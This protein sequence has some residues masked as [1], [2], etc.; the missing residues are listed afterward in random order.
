MVWP[1]HH[2]APR[3]G[4]KIICRN[5]PKVLVWPCKPPGPSSSVATF[6][7]GNAGVTPPA[8]KAAPE[9]NALDRTG[10][11]KGDKIYLSGKIGR[12]NF[13][14]ALYLYQ[15]HTVLGPLTRGLDNR[16]PY[17][18][19]EAQLIGHYASGCIDTSDGTFSALNTLS[20]LNGLGYRLQ[21]LP[22][23]SLPKTLAHLFRRPPELLVLRGG[24]GVRAPLRHPAGYRSRLPPKRQGRRAQILSPGGVCPRTGGERTSPSRDGQG[25]DTFLPRSPELRRQPRILGSL[26]GNLVEHGIPRQQ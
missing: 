21:K 11:Q 17:R 23:L 22:L 15:E 19:E 5:S 26:A 13:E 10:I 14:A 24:R 1:R 2:R 6:L 4:P 20:H 7:W 9:K 16:F 3:M 8:S 12:G 25:P 18:G